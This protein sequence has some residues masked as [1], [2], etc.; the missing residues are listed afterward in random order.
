MGY[1]AKGYRNFRRELG[2]PKPEAYDLKEVLYTR[3]YYV[4]K[5][6][7]WGLIKYRVPVREVITRYDLKQERER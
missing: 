7:L 3:R 2:L 5:R 1:Y 6:L 4:T